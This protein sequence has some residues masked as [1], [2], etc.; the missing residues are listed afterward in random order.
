VPIAVEAPFTLVLGGRLV[1]GRIDAVFD[2]AD[3]RPQVVDWK[4]GDARR[5]DPLQLACYRL[6]W[7]ELNGVP[8][9]EVDAVFYDLHS[10]EVVRPDRLPDRSGL[11]AVLERLPGSVS[12]TL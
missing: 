8:A 1:R 6:A 7:A 2:G 5:S 4:T 3:G 9:D 12:L 10:A 11:E